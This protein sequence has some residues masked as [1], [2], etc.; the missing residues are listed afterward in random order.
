MSGIEETLATGAST[1]ARAWIL[2]RADGLKLGFTDH[3][4]EL[5]VDGVTCTASSGL[6]AGAIDRKTGLSVDNAEVQ[7]ALTHD[8]IRPEDI[9]AGR[10]DAAE[11]TCYLVDWSTPENLE[12]L[13]RGNLGEISWGDGAFST[14]L[15]GLSERL[16]EVQ[17]RVFQSRCDAVLGDSRC[18]KGLGP[19]FAV[20]TNVVSVDDGHLIRVPIF[21]DYAPKWFERGRVVVLTGQAAG[22]EERV[23]TDRIRE[24]DRELDL[25]GA[26]RQEL[27]P[28][29]RIRIEAGCDKRHD[30]CRFKFDNILNFRGF[31]NIPGEDWMM[32]Y[33][34]SSK[35][36]NGERL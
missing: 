8:M 4:R 9:R 35:A 19:L 13:F 32:A 23:K 24:N 11:I 26:L 30:T 20:E 34:S 14:E 33:P 28:G 18:G 22:L 29:D 1:V 3:D 5:Q 17:G 21:R 16:N 27:H 7:G 31:P 6:S 12:I 36:N 25:W 2:R 15:R 10:W